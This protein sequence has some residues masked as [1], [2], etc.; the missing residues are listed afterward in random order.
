MNDSKFHHTL[1]SRYLKIYQRKLKI[2][3]N[4]PKFLIVK[5]III[6]EMIYITHKDTGIQMKYS[7]DDDMLNFIYFRPL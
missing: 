5:T 7:Y 3:Y 4:I 1:K 2:Q 6:T